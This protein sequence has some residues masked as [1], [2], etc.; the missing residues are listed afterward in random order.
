MNDDL[1][2]DFIKVVS[3][4]WFVLIAF[5]VVSFFSGCDSGWTLCGWEVK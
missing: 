5:L 1:T 2:R 3:V 4:L